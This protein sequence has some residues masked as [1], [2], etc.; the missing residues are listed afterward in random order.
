MVW[1][2]WTVN[3]P[4]VTRHKRRPPVSTSILRNCRNYNEND[5]SRS[6]MTPPPQKKIHSMWKLNCNGPLVTRHKRRP[7]VSIYFE[8]MK[9]LTIKWGHSEWTPPHNNENLW[10]VKIELSRTLSNSPQEASAS[11]NIFWASTGTYN[12][13]RPFRMKPPPTTMKIYSMWKLNCNGPLVTR[14]KRRPPVS[15][16][17]KQMQELTIKWC[18]SE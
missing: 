9:E 4:L 17:F 8:Q 13:M 2:N 14:H 1:E 7:P 18:H 10:Y 12:K 11:F 3:G 16:Y 6:D 5:I 15:I